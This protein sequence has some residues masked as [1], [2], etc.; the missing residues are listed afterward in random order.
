MPYWFGELIFGGACTWRG[1]FS[2]FYGISSMRMKRR[3]GPLQLNSRMGQN[4]HTGEQE[5]KW[6]KGNKE[7][8]SLNKLISFLVKVL[9]EVS[10]VFRNTCLFNAKGSFALPPRIQE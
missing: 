7:L 5:T 2:E 8:E 10:E 3:F 1:L 9:D 6:G 4:H